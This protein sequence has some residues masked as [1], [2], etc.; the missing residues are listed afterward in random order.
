MKHRTIYATN[1]V[2]NTFNWTKVE[3]KQCELKRNVNIFVPF[4]W[5]K[6][7]LKQYGNK[8]KNTGDGLLIEL[9]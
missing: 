7:E 1:G 9:R 3:L 2:T 6:V 8:E 5:T 4:N